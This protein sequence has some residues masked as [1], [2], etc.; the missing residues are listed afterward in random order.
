MFT[1][2]SGTKYAAQKIQFL[3]T[4]SCKWPSTSSLKSFT[5]FQQG[6]DELLPIYFFI[7]ST[8]VAHDITN[9][10]DFDLFQRSF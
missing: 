8:C 4:G 2:R 5:K 3:N 7:S 1:K 10:I 9:L 6:M